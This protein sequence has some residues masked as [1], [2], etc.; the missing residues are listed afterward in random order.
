M[1]VMPHTPLNTQTIHYSVQSRAKKRWRADLGDGDHHNSTTPTIIISLQSII[2]M[3]CGNAM[4]VCT[5]V[6]VGPRNG[7][8]ILWVVASI[9]L[10]R[11]EDKVFP[12]A[13]KVATTQGVKLLCSGVVGP[14]GGLKRAL[15]SVGPHRVVVHAH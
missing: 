11:R 2:P 14:W 5:K 10:E 15:F 8:G 3:W 1:I 13:K 7:V 6:K 4:R 9:P 12:Q